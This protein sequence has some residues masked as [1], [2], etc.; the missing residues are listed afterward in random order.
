[1]AP[2]P[3]NPLTYLTCPAHTSCDMLLIKLFI[4][5]PDVAL[6]ALL[7]RE[8]YEQDLRRRQTKLS[9]PRQSVVPLVPF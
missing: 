7:Y 1:M 4:L 3:H 9:R 6:A 2:T 8:L 5:L